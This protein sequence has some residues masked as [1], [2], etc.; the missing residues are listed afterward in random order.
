MTNAVF[1]IFFLLLGFGVIAGELNRFG[2]NFG[3]G[4]ERVQ[5]ERVTRLLQ[6][7]EETFMAG[8]VPRY[9]R[10]RT[11]KD[12]P[13]PWG[14]LTWESLENLRTTGGAILPTLRRLKILAQTHRQI[15]SEAKAKSSQAWA[16]AVV[17]GAMTPVF[18]F[19]LYWLL[20]GIS[21]RLWSW[22]GLCTLGAGLSLTAC[23]WLVHLAETARWGGLPKRCRPWILVTYCAGEKFLAFVRSGTPADLSWT[24]VLQFI[25]DEAPELALDWGFSI[26]E[27]PADR[28]KSAP[29]LRSSLTELGER[30]RKSAQVSLM[31]GSPCTER[32]ETALSSLSQEVKSHIERELSLLGTRALKPLFL[33][34]APALLGLLVSGLG[35][36]LLQS[37]AI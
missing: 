14:N 37:G 28:A 12:L 27:T 15:L 22:I 24:K 32:V 9:E 8:L 29:G 20:P 7:I 10:W 30:I 11:L 26:W 5:L 21:E 16:Q 35:I 3:I 19:T 4:K 36:C 2:A 18:G 33:L 6:E 34:V 13:A 23:I 1:C 31:E 17:C 25:S